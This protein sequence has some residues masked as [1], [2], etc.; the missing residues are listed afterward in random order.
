MYDLIIDLMLLLSGAYLLVCGVLNIILY[1]VIKS[2][3][4]EAVATVVEIGTK[5]WRGTRYYPIFEYCCNDG[6]IC[7]VNYRQAAT[8]TQKYHVGQ[9]CEIIYRADKPKQIIL[10]KKKTSTLIS[11]AI[12]ILFGFT[13]LYAGLGG[14]ERILQYIFNL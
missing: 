8:L 2:N 3:G 9:V 4:I 11:V 14:I 6:Y 1:M 7:R 10:K 5:Y 13:I 12:S